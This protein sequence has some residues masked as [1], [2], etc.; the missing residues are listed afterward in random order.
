[1]RKVF[2]N[3][4]LS[5]TMFGLCF[6]F[7][8]GQSIAGFKE[9]NSDKQDHHQQPITYLSYLGSGHFA[10]AIFENWESEFLQ[11]GAY[12]M[13]TAFL[14]QKGSSESKDPDAPKGEEEKA[15]EL[16]QAKDDPLAPRP[17]RRGGLPLKLYEHSLSLTLFGLFALSFIGH[18]IGGAKEYNE[19]QIEH[20]HEPVTTLQFMGSSAFWFQSLQNWQSEFLA[21]GALSVLSIWFREKDSPES[22][23]VTARDDETGSS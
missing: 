6:L 4:G 20:G 8:I 13:L 17:V 9:A 14:F 1:M 22:K 21:V 7:I 5:I 11:M 10:E 19:E 15:K 18:G 23:A 12:V 16:K 3:N 2:R